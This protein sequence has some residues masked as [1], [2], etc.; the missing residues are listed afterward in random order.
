MGV[1]PPAFEHSSSL[2]CGRAAGSVLKIRSQESVLNAINI[3]SRST[4]IAGMI[5]RRGYNS[6]NYNIRLIS[7]KSRILLERSYSWSK[8]GGT[9]TQG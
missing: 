9:I 6:V 2:K 7:Y 8:T 1:D 4:K 5:L 3:V